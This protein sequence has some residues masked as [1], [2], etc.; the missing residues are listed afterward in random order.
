MTATLR[1]RQPLRSGCAR[2][3]EASISG[4][5]NWLW[6]LSGISGIRLTASC[7]GQMKRAVRLLNFD[8]LLL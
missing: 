4:D 6:L 3:D 1:R 5:D 7:S 2:Y 8:R